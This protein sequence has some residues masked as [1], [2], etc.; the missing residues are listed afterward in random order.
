MVGPIM[1]ASCPRIDM[2]KE[3]RCI[4]RIWGAPDYQ[5][6]PKSYFQNQFSM[7]KINGSFFKKKKSF[8]KNNNLG[9][10]FL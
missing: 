6:V 1:Q 5:K 3:N 2:L 7:S 10:H 9:D 8:Y 4:L